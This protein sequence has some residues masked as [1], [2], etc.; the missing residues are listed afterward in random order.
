MARAEE[1]YVAGDL[2]GRARPR[3]RERATSEREVECAGR[4]DERLQSIRLRGDDRRE[5]TENAL[6]LVAGIGR[7]LREP[8]VQ[9]D[10]RERLD[11]QRLSRARRVM[12]DTGDLRACRCTNREHGTAAALGEKRLLQRL[13]H[14]VRACDAR[15][16][17]TDAGASVAELVA[18]PAQ[19]RRGGITHVGSVFLDAPVDLV[20]KPGEAE[21]DRLDELGQHRLAKDA[22]RLHRHSNRHGDR[23]Q[24]VRSKHA[25]ANGARSSTPHV[26]DPGE[27]WRV[28]VREH[29]HR[30]GGQ[31]L[32]ACHRRRIRRGREL[33]HER[34]AVV[35]RGEGCETIHDRPQ[36]ERGER[37]S[38]HNAPV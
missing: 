25:A 10:D 26:A 7:R 13:A 38:V 29:R 31:R 11:E 6:D 24:L 20:G 9:L 22:L 5:L 12:D 15:Q 28:A 3:A 30:G 35:G 19:E 27:L 34:H 1:S 21:V 18:Q 23:A 14:L 32:A 36:L 16:L 2:D 17:V 8:V 33:A 4:L 37:R